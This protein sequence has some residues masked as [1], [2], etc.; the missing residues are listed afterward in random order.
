[1]PDDL[2]DRGRVVSS[3]LLGW[4][5]FGVLVVGVPPNA[6]GEVFLSAALV[7][8]AAFLMVEL[9]TAFVQS[10]WERVSSEIAQTGKPGML[11]SLDF[12]SLRYLLLLG[13][14]FSFWRCHWRFRAHKQSSDHR[15]GIRHWR[16]VHPVP[17]FQTDGRNRTMHLQVLEAWCLLGQWRPVARSLSERNRRMR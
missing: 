17:Q 2:H 4:L 7:G 5:G 15:L 6:Q 1:M 13:T 3:A 10:D 14:S 12:A 16:S 9:L 8:I 11:S